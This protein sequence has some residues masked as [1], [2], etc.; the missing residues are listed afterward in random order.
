MNIQNYLTNPMGKGSSVLMLSQ[1]RNYL[2]NQYR[3][4]YSRIKMTWYNLSD[5]YYIAHV[6]IPSVSVDNLWYDVLLEFDA[7][8]I[9]ENIN[10]VNRANTRVFSNCPSFVYTYAYVFNKNMDLIEWC[11]LKYPKEILSKEPE[12]RNPNR[13]VSYEKSLYFA[14]KYVLSNGRNYKTAAKTKGVKLENYQK[15]YTLVKSSEDIL[16][17]YSQ[18]KKKMTS[19]K[20]KEATQIKT[21]KTLEKE[22]TASK[23]NKQTTKIVTKTSKTKK[24]VRSSKVKK[25]NKK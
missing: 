21:P 9:P 24:I 2:D 23:K 10:V 3:E 18:K 1:T 7:E 20:E 15:L 14:I 12:K 22:G 13:L 25:I 11:K 5:R 8:T 4:I 6:K 19:K 17:A 16:Q